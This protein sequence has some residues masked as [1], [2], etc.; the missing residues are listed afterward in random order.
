[1]LLTI[2]TTHRPATDLGYLLHKHPERAQAFD[3]AF[4]QAHVFYPEATDERCSAALLLEIDPVAL[5]R[6]ADANFSLGQYVNDRPYAASSLM[7]VAIARVYSSALAGKSD[8]RPQLAETP[9]P[10]RVEIGA[11]PCRGGKELLEKLFA[12]LGY[13]LTVAGSALDE[14]FPEWGDS[15]YFSVTLEARARLKDLLTHLYVLIPVLDDDK[16]YYVG[17]EE[18]EKLLRHGEGWLASHPERELIAGRYL[19]HRRSLKREALD[20]LLGEEAPETDEIASLQDAGEASLEAG[21]SLNQQRLDAVL[22]LLKESG[23]RRVL[24]LGCGEGQLLQRLLEEPQFEEIVGMDVSH[25][26]LERAGGRLRLEQMPPRQRTRIQ[27]LQG[28]L[29]YRDPRLAGYDAAALVEVI[30][31]L[32]PPRLAACERVIFECA[33]PGTVVVTTP[34][35]EYNARWES[36]P[37]GKVRH[38][39]H[40]FEWSREQFET[41]GREVGERFGYGVRF[42]P[43]GPQ[44]LEV[45]PPTQVGLFTTREKR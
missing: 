36:L 43:I 32:D 13:E 12:P 23:G 2:T 16:H 20:R 4:G 19:K 28:S 1:M 25:R 8:E 6:R 35:A 30:E 14:V 29:L 17:D 18:V 31:H 45:G 40:R 39:D 21:L 5:R 26:A 41:W 3:L 33:R 27:L 11:L 38:W 7:S 9:I 34:N 24:D 22:T 42:L 15:P 44:D 37:A 10:L